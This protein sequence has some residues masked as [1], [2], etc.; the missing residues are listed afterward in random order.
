MNKTLDVK[1]S[2]DLKGKVSDVIIHGN[3]DAFQLLCKAS[4]E[5]QGWMKSTK[6]MQMPDGCLVQVS[7][8]QRGAD[9]TYAVAEA[10]FYVPDVILRKDS[11]RNLRFEIPEM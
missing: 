11:R 7:T 8:Q 10:L 3:P 6:V 9:G 4:S 5:S 2:D 1:D